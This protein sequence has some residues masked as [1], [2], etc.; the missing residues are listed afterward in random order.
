M[1]TID[2]E[3]II[4]DYKLTP[5][6]HEG[7]YFRRVFESASQVE[8]SSFQSPFHKEV[9]PA[10][11]AIYYLITSDS[12]S[13]LHRLSSHE[14]WT[15]ICGDPAEQLTIDPSNVLTVNL[16]GSQVGNGGISHVPSRYWQGTKLIKGGEHGFALFSTVVVPGYD[17][18]DF[19]MADASLLNSLEQKE[20]ELARQFLPHGGTL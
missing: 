12:Y 13:A 7:G 1:G 17:H 9:L 16:I 15:F 8:T 19:T 20:R 3:Q 14:V 2:I 10:V 6:D 5:L 4:A 18:S 11:S